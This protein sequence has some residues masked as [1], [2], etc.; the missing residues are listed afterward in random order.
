MSPV[1]RSGFSLLACWL[2]LTTVGC[3]TFDL[4]HIDL[5]SR[6]ATARNPAIRIVCLW[7]PAEG[8][9]PKGVPCKGF[10]GQ[11]LFLTS[12]SLPVSV[13]GDIRVYLFDD[14]GTAE[15]Q[16]KP[17][18]QFDF[19]TGAWAQHYSYGTLGPA[20]NVF[21]PYMRRGPND[22]TCALRVRLTPK[23]GPAIFSD[24][25]SIKLLGFENR[26][27]AS[28]LIPLTDP[29]VEQTTPEDLTAVNKRRKTTTITLNGKN[30]EP[31]SSTTT[32]PGDAPQNTIQLATFEDIDKSD[33][34][35]LS[36]DDVRIRQLEQMVKELRAQQGQLK[37]DDQKMPAAPP[38]TLE[39]IG[40]TPGRIRVRSA[41]GAADE[42]E[43]SADRANVN[44]PREDATSSYSTDS[45]RR[46][47]RAVPSERRH[48]LDDDA[49]PAISVRSNRS[50]VHPLLDSSDEP[51]RAARSSSTAA[52]H[53]P[54]K[55]HPLDDLGEDE[56]PR[57]TMP[58]TVRVVEPEPYGES[59]R[60]R[61]F[62]PFD[63][64]ETDAVETTSVND[65][66][67]VRRQLKAA[68]R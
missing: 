32:T 56:P 41:E 40:I 26:K 2:M 18:H 23:K 37:G 38:R 25:T 36:S 59:D 16:A 28:T 39:E 14:Q 60:S 44:R 31:A 11:V 52:S 61:G 58:K 9:D 29:R 35:P 66:P 45:V 54:R 5:R 68:S 17:L 19:D 51:V 10:A 46:Q 27:P 22:A 30:G 20:Y 43:T 21:I 63:P 7:E 15:D 62:D 12:S 42:Q 47:L 6:K 55:R 8:R 24:M 57:R 13:E 65:S 48:P 4:T 49:E 50:A 53:A 3:A 33:M 67:T 34:K 64:I 1:S